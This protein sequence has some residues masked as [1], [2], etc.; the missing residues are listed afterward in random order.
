MKRE[1]L[2]EAIFATMQQLH[3]TS[4]ASLQISMKKP[5]ISH[6]QIELLLIVKQRQP[7][8][9]KDL[10]AHMRLTPGAIT[11]LLEGLAERNYVA[12]E[13]AEYDRRITNISL[14]PTGARRLKDLWEQRKAMLRQVMETLDTE[15]LAVMLRVQEKMLRHFEQ[16][17]KE[18]AS[19]KRTTKK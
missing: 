19:K 7:V 12:R 11:Q 4:N 15:E 5:D 2:I 18:A 6:T 3:R 14:T 16:K 9:V 10:A 17:G 8:N 1:Q 13:P